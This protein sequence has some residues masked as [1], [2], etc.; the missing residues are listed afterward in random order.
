MDIRTLCDWEEPTLQIQ[1]KDDMQ[2]SQFVDYS[3]HRFEDDICS[4][5]S[6]DS[7]Y[8]EFFYESNRSALV[9]K[10]VPATVGSSSNSILCKAF[11]SEKSSSSKTY[12]TYQESYES[13]Y[14]EVEESVSPVNKRIKLEHEKPNDSVNQL[15][16][17]EQRN[18]SNAHLSENDRLF[19]IWAKTAIK[20]SIDCFKFF[21]PAYHSQHDANSQNNLDAKEAEE[22]AKVGHFF[23]NWQIDT[24]ALFSDQFT[25]LTQGYKLELSTLEAGSYTIGTS[26][27]CQ[28]KVIKSMLGSPS[29]PDL[30][31]TITSFGEGQQKYLTLSDQFKD[32]D[33][34]LWLEPGFV[35]YLNEFVT[36][37]VYNDNVFRIFDVSRSVYTDVMRNPPDLFFPYNSNLI[38]IGEAITDFLLK[39]NFYGKDLIFD[40]EYNSN[41]RLSSVIYTDPVAKLQRV[42]PV[43][44]IDLIKISSKKFIMNFNFSY[45][46]NTYR[47]VLEVNSIG[48]P[49]LG[50]A[51]PFYF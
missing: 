28:L 25:L 34:K 21:D 22:V 41:T 27:I 46:T 1:L 14:P 29:C 43:R 20:G 31:G 6:F 33:K 3:K 16:T 48:Q 11:V 50:G 5:S 36:L 15:S 47:T 40:I 38:F 26:R 19:E 35:Y 30:L 12:S 45:P 32:S 39:V 4:T 42:Y 2:I 23:L 24:I 9:Q 10:S 8:L 37:E 7:D 49:M 17:T 18:P 44:A 13:E 51:N